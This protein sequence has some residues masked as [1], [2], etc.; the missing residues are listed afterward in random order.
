MDAEYEEKLKGLLVHEENE[1][2]GLMTTQF[3]ALPP[4]IVP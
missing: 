1:A 2:S 3:M 4:D